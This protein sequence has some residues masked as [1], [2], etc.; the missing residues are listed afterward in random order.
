MTPRHWPLFGLRVATPR[1][2][3]R[4]PTDAE[5]D[6]LADVAA[7]G[8]HDPAA[9][10]FMT[11]WTDNAPP[12]LQQGLLQWNWRQRA[13]WTSERWNLGLGVFVEGHIVG[14]QD[15]GAERFAVLRSV[16]TGSWLGRA[17]QGRGVGTE[18]RAAVL[19]LAFAGL[20]ALEAHS[21]AW[22][23]NM[24]SLGVSAR[25]GYE[26]NG[27][28]RAARRDAADEIV[29]LRLTRDRWAAHAR[30]DVTVTGLEPCLALFGL[31]PPEG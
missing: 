22:T 8:V 31:A 10:P 20:G 30:D 29:D 4:L 15:I 12:G 26:A 16:T 7:D 23:D 21:G 1:L 3:L 6:D 11:P 18:M 5:L 27:R 2:E 19:H 25:F 28:R 17:H 9:M 13:E 14:V 24:R